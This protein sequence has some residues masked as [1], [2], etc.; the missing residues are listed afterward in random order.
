MEHGFKKYLIDQ[1]EFLREETKAKNKITDHLFILKLSL[2]D[3]KIFSYKN[4]QINK[5]SNKVDN[6]SVF[7]NCSPQRPCFKENSNYLKDNQYIR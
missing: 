5:S 2:R 1:I 6:K 4:F 7:R 3:E